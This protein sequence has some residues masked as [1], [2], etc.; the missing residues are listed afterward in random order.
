MV[1]TTM[2]TMSNG[3]AGG[4][5]V[6]PAEPLKI[7][8]QHYR[9]ILLDLH[10]SITSSGGREKFH[11]KRIRGSTKKMTARSAGTTASHLC[12]CY[13]K[14]LPEDSQLLRSQGIVTRGAVWVSIGLI[15]HG[16]HVC[17]LQASRNWAEGRSHSSYVSSNPRRL[18]T[19]STA[20]FCGKYS[21]ASDYH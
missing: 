16:H 13:L 17:S 10:R 3:K 2:K 9:T 7:K 12:P 4:P 20:S 6:L 1:T 5:D 14:R 8:L 15:D 21:L 19:L 11:S 18:T